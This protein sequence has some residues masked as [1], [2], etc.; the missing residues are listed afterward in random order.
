MEHF[1]MEITQKTITV[2]K[3]SERMNRKPISE[4]VNICK[5]AIDR[6][7]IIYHCNG[8][9]KYVQTHHINYNILVT[10]QV[11]DKL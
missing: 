9:D 7:T 5:S 1:I 8:H 10:K 4:T 2:T 11:Q 3:S 6:D